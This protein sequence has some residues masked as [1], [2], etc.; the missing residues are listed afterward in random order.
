MSAQ[1][2]A[3]FSAPAPNG[4]PFSGSGSLRLENSWY[5]SP[6]ASRSGPGARVQRTVSH[7]F[8]KPLLSVSSTWPPALAKSAIFF[9][10]ASLAT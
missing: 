2:E 3:L 10:S 9:S 1:T 4:S 7:S 6:A 5:E 8:V